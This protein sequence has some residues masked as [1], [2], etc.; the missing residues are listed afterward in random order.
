MPIHPSHYR[1]LPS[2]DPSFGPSTRLAALFAGE[3]LLSQHFLHHPKVVRL[4]VDYVLQIFD[5][6]A[7]F[8]DFAVVEFLR[9]TGR[10]LHVEAGAYVDDH[11]VGVCKFAWNVE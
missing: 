3:H 11:M 1:E 4:A 8:F 9:I 6:L 7:E 10:L 5:V 2:R